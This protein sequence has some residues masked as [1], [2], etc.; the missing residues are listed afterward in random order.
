M[1]GALAGHQKTQVLI[2]PLAFAIG[3]T[4]DTF[5]LKIL[6]LPHVGRCS[7]TFI[8]D[9]KNVTYYPVFQNVI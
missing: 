1:E 9:H 8:R 5:P 6:T 7:E 2:P 3:S 4:L